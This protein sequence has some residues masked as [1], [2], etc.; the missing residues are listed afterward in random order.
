MTTT[1]I[2]TTDAHDSVKERL[3][4][5]KVDFD[6]ADLEAPIMHF[7]HATTIAIAELLLLLQISEDALVR[8]LV[9]EV[10]RVEEIETD[11][12]DVA[13]M[14]I[15]IANADPIVVARI[16]ETTK[17]VA[18]AEAETLEET[19]IEDKAAA[20]ALDRLHHTAILLTTIHQKEERRKYKRSEITN[21]VKYR[22]KKKVNFN[23]H[24]RS[25]TAEALLHLRPNVETVEALD[26]KTYAEYIYIYTHSFSRTELTRARTTHTHTHKRIN[27]R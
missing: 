19:F 13:I 10:L 20:V 2:I 22:P 16:D 1:I 9:P 17:T 4:T 23:L 5:T 21:K 3:N 26:V 6:L 8:A 14:M 18:A 12:A 7:F 24:R 27:T 15:T 25:V 11:E